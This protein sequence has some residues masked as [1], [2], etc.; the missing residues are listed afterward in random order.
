MRNTVVLSPDRVRM[1]ERFGWIDHRVMLEGHL[2][3]MSQRAQCLY[4]FL[5]LAADR[6][7]VSWYS[8]LR[9]R[10]AISLPL[11]ELEAA[12]RELVDLDLVAFVSP[13]YQ[14]LSVPQKRIAVQHSEAGKESATAEEISEAVK[15]I[16]RQLRGG[17]SC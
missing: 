1:A 4:L 11:K 10:E 13:Y 8:D 6:K 3:R 2:Q 5:C 9:L 17:I 12:R 7:G 14:V 15:A 16:R